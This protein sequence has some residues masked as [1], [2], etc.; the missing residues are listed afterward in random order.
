MISVDAAGD[1]SP[2]SKNRSLL[3]LRF[4][5]F[6]DSF[7]CEQHARVNRRNWDALDRSRWERA[8]AGG[9]ISY[10]TSRDQKLGLSA[11]GPHAIPFE[12]AA[13]QFNITFMIGD[14]QTEF[15]SLDRIREAGMACGYRFEIE[16]FEATDSESRVTVCNRGIAPLY[17]DAYVAVDGVRAA[18]SLRG[19]LPGRRRTFTVAA[20]GAAPQLDIVSDRL[21]P[22]QRIEFDAALD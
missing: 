8:P 5:V 21:V 15:Q 17:H 9:E 16:R 14:G 12:R 19:L 11:E 1:W 3:E 13:E 18:E 10:Y 2:L 7:L 20:G 22:G 4:G 6:D